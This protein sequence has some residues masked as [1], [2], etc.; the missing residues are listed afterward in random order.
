LGGTAGSAKVTV[1]ASLPNSA[2]T[3]ESS[4]SAEYW[5]Y[6]NK[7]TG[8]TVA[9]ATSNIYNGGSLD[10]TATLTLNGGSSVYGTLS[11][12]MPT[13]TWSST[14][15]DK[16][17]VKER[18][19][20]ASQVGSDIVATMKVL[21]ASD[22]EAN[23]QAVIT[24]EVG[25]ASGTSTLTCVAKAIVED[26][27][28]GGTSTTVWVGQDAF[29]LTAT[30][31][32]GGSTLTPASVPALN[33]SWVS[34][35]TDVASVNNGTITL[36]GT[37]GSAKVTV[38]ASLPNSATTI[39]SSASAEYWV[40]VN[41]V[42]GISVSPAADNINIGGTLD[43]TATLT[44]NDAGVVY[45]TLSSNMPTVTWS[46][47]GYDKISVKERTS[48]ASQVGSDIVA[49]MKVSAASD[50]EANK[51]AVI[52]AEV[53]DASGTSTLTCVI[54][55]TTGTGTGHGYSGWNNN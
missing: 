1:T 39:E 21:A 52:T 43:L 14:G 29:T 25:D 45:G 20:T 27:S 36:G 5:V 49:T 22:A 10:L 28:L 41:K 53:G 51:Q 18:T 12:N 46:S 30:V 38:T 15:Y 48:T 19:S 23:K 35:N 44:I 40:Y 32:G 55:S 31:T 3:I 16:I 7:V 9:P 37:A 50:A 4:A 47:T 24:A 26:V 42:T 17:S 2:T 13:V 6:V 11:S 54:P 33:I 34:S 8:V